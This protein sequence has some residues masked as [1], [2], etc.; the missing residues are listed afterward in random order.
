MIERIVA[1]LGRRWLAIHLERRR[2]RRPNRGRDPRAAVVESLEPRILLT[3]DFGDAPSPYPTT[4]AENGAQHTDTGPTL[5]ATRDSELDGTH[6]ANAT[7]DGADEDGVT[8]GTI[9]VGVV[10]STVL[11]N[12]AGAPSGAK[13]DAWI[14]FNGDGNWGG[15]GEQI[16]ANVAVVNGNNIITFDVPSTAKNGTTFARF[17]L[18][19]AGDLGPGGLAADGEVEDY[20]VTVIPPAAS[21]DFGGPNTVSTAADGAFSVIAAD[22][23]SDGDMDMLSASF[24][25]DKI[26]WYENDGSQNFTAHNVNTPDPDG[27]GA[28]QGNANG[29]SN[30][31]AADLDGDGDLDVLSASYFDDKIAWYENDGS[32]NFTAHTISTAADAAMSVLAV[33][34]DGDGDLDV[35]SASQDD[36][37]IAWYENDGSQT[38]TAHTISTAANGVSSVFAADVDGDGDLD[39]LS[40]SFIDDKIAWYENDGSQT[41]TAHTISTAANGA[42]SVFAVDVDGDGDLDVLSASRFDDK[43]AWYEND[44]NQIFTAHTISTVADDAFSVFAADVDG[45]GDRDILSASRDNDKIMWY[46]ND[47]SQNFTEHTIS[48]AA[49]GATSVFAADVDGDGDLDILSA[50]QNDDK[51]AW[52]ENSIL[53]PVNLSVSTATGVESAA[54]VVTVT[55]TATSP[56]VGNQTVDLAVTGTNITN[57]DFIL[58]K[59]RITILNGHLTGSVT[60]TVVDDGI[61]EGTETATLTI[62]NPSVPLI[63]G[64]TTSQNVTITDTEIAGIPPVIA[65]F[66]TTVAYTEN[67]APRVLDA[68][69]TVT[70]LD[71]TFF[72]GGVLTVSLTANAEADDRL[73]IHPVT[74]LLGVSGSNLT[75]RGTTIATST[76]GTGGADLVITFNANATASVVQTVLRN[77]TYRSVS[78]NPSTLARTVQVALTDGTGGTSNL[79]TK[80][81]NVVATIPAPAS[82]PVTMANPLAVAAV[83]PV[84]IE[85]FQHKTKPEVVQI[86]TELNL[87]TP[88]EARAEHLLSDHPTAGHGGY[89]FR[90]EPTQSTSVASSSRHP[91]SVW[92]PVHECRTPAERLLDEVFARFE[93]WV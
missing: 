62:S 64:A 61:V 42:F 41:F 82:A 68:N 66:D 1:T 16:A 75:Y 50:S 77:I 39:V 12:V 19:T 85:S 31:F 57:G 23:D 69:A 21:L 60:F 8:F 73:E 86:L 79:P 51:I 76:G 24:N 7:A 33:D 15:P 48:T 38:F 88:D 83:D 10:G 47:G 87:A 80:T 2:P 4:I 44:G 37:K 55:A 45:D 20:A 58:S 43:I 9:Q 52:Y 93:E 29:A 25:D 65:G 18:S 78:A 72:N 63:L 40:A 84:L 92:R 13:L 11:V 27:G 53:I 67:A 17:R 59:F 28:G 34:V 32:Q 49:D 22:V 71:T 5:G 90:S 35:L 30:V 14:D 54:T 6:S 26:A 74:R 46:E 56:V 81:I 36:D 3:A 70:D 89:Q 91:T